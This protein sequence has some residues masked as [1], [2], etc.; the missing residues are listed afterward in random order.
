MRAL[1]RDFLKLV[2]DLGHTRLRRTGGGTVLLDLGTCVV[3]LL[4]SCLTP[5]GYLRLLGP[6][7]VA[8]RLKAPDL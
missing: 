7:L 1:V 6:R 3:S 5:L 8:L 4:R 2:G